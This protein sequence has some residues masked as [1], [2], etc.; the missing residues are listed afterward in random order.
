MG[1]GF[2][3]RMPTT[4][5]SCAVILGD[6][7][8]W[9]KTPVHSQWITDCF[10]CRQP[11]THELCKKHANPRN[12]WAAARAHAGKHECCQ[13]AKASGSNPGKGNVCMALLIL[14]G[15]IVF[16]F[17]KAIWATF[18]G[19]YLNRKFPLTYSFSLS[20]TLSF[21]LTNSL[22]HARTHARSHARTHAL[23]HSLT[24]S[25]SL[26]LSFSVCFY[27]SLSLSLCVSLS[28]SL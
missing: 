24:P 13:G 27:L 8:C 18:W 23:T 2:L 12:D 1:H 21:S 3:C 4:I 5:I 16:F 28:I 6:K 25:R 17:A 26:P 10:K 15:S 7:K 20:R 19:G 14:G 22:T 9:Y 11:S